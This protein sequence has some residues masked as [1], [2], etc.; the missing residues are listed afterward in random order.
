MRKRQG[1]LT[2]G[3]ALILIMFLVQGCGLKANPAPRW[4]QP[5]KLVTDIRLQEEAG[6]IFIQ[7]RIPEQSL[8]LTQF[9]ITRSESGTQGQSCPDCPQGEVRIAD[10]MSGE[11]KLVIVGARVFGYQD[12]DVKPGRLYRYRVVGCDRTGSCSEASAPVELSVPAD[13]S[14]R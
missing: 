8:P 10:L 11:Q 1:R 4:I 12:T 9:Q 2:L 5:L 7:W 6:G 13:T 3:V 14:S